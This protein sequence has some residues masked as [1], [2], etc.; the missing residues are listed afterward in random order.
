MAAS[1]F[2]RKYRSCPQ[3][4]H[5]VKTY[6]DQR[7][8]GNLIGLWISD[9]KGK[10]KIR[11]AGAEKTVLNLFQRLHGTFYETK[12]LTI[13]SLGF[14]KAG[15]HCTASKG[16]CDEKDKLSQIDRV[17]LIKNGEHSTHFR[18]ET[19]AKKRGSAWIERVGCWE[20]S[21]KEVS[22]SLVTAVAGAECWLY[23]N[24]EGRGFSVKTNP[25]G[26]VHRSSSRK[27]YL[28]CSYRSRF[29][30]PVRF[31]AYGQFVQLHGESNRRK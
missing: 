16:T 8:I 28:W 15:I 25:I 21:E 12:W 29:Y 30:M 7:A 6:A 1:D 4:R 22:R 19:R 20:E 3:E 26:S 18:P 14:D 31:I 27:L 9:K 2:I 11:S 5:I 24:I 23:R 10:R 13:N 17:L